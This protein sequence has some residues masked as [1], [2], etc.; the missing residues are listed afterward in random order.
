MNRAS[1]SCLGRAGATVFHSYALGSSALTLLSAL[2]GDRWDVVALFNHI[3]PLALLPALALLPGSL[4]ARRPRLALLL[5]PSL[6]ALLRW[7]GPQFL[8]RSS[9]ARTQAPHFRLLT[10]NIHAETEQLQPMLAVIGA[11]D[12]DV[13]AIQELSPAAATTFARELAADYPYQALHPNHTN[14]ILGQGLLSRYPIETDEYWQVHLGHQRAV[15]VI[16]ERPIVVYNTHPIHPFVPSDGSVLPFNLRPRQ[17]EIDELLRRAQADAGAVLLVGDF[18]MSD[19]SAPYRQITQRYQDAYREVGWGLGLTCPDL[20]YQQ[21]L[22]PEFPMP[23]PLPP[24]TRIDY[25]FHSAAVRP[26]A[27]R[28]WPDSGGSDHRPLVA[29]LQ[30]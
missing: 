8:P 22:A 13:V 2:V 20:R 21:A 19:R 3:V 6:L 15:I 11:V 10:Y 25:I 27:I 12:A 16:A 18:N 26:T 17:Q 1:R 14:P 23:L 30:W 29:D 7:Y 4:A 24:L 28:V 9:S 5:V